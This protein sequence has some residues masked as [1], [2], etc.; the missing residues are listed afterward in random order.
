MRGSLL[1]PG[2]L[3]RPGSR[4][5]GRQP[6][7]SASRRGWG[8]VSLPSAA[9]C[10]LT[11]AGEGLLCAGRLRG[12]PTKLALSALP[13]LAFLLTGGSTPGEK[14]HA[15]LGGADTAQPASRP[16]DGAARWLSPLHQASL[17]LHGTKTLRGRSG[18]ICG[19]LCCRPWLQPGTSR[20]SCSHGTDPALALLL[21][22]P[23]HATQPSQAPHISLGG[24]P[25]P[26]GQ[27]ESI[28]LFLPWTCSQSWFAPRLLVPVHGPYL[29]SEGLHGCFCRVREGAKEGFLFSIRIQSLR[30]RAQGEQL[31][32]VPTKRE[33][34]CWISPVPR[35]AETYKESEVSGGTGDGPR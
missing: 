34:T 19:W 7:A 24:G 27:G 21:L 31:R 33:R 8:S 2:L 30:G 29:Q 10:V 17:F 12:N 20:D 23:P 16:W 25:G 22:P 5:G 1:A 3:G 28:T 32:L 18:H 6:A 26:S 15:V 11:V 4:E 14:G 35:P 9:R 13:A